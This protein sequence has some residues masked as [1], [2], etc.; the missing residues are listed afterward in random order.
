MRTA[1]RRVEEKEL[2][3]LKKALAYSA[4]YIPLAVALL[5][6]LFIVVMSLSKKWP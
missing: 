3:G 5:P 4:I 6:H 1:G 2:T